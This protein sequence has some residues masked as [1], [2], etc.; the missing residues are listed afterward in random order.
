M[1]HRTILAGLAAAFIP[2]SALAHAGHLG[3]L[4]GHSHWV[5]AAA[6]AGAALV[7][8]IIA[9]RDRK[10]KQADEAPEAETAEEETAGEAA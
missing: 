3:E 2:T 8:G 5:G 7:A 9:L 1:F 10:R 6:L 4:A